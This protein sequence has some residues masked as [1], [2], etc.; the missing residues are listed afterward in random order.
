MTRKLT[1]ALSQQKQQTEQHNQKLYGMLGITIGGQRRVEVPNRNS[2]VYV[3]LRNSQSELIQAFNNRVAPSYNLPVVLKREGNRYVILDVDTTRYD[4]N[5]SSYSPYLPR[6]GNTHSFDPETGGGGDTV[7]VYPRQ[8][9]PLLAFPS[10]S[11]GSPHAI[12]S[13]YTLKKENGTWMYVGNTGTASFTPYNPPNSGTAVMGLIALDTN[14]GNPYLLINSGTTFLDTITGSSQ[15]YPY[16][17]TLTNPSDIPIAAVRLVSGTSRLTWDN[18]YDVRQFVHN[19][20]SGSAAGISSIA[21]QDEGVSQGNATTFNFVGDGVTATISGSVARIF[22][23]TNTGSSASDFEGDPNSAVLTDPSGTLFTPTW[24]KWGTASRPYLEFGADVPDKETNAGKMGYGMGGDDYEFN[25]NG[26]GTGSNRKV[27]ISDDLDVDDTIQARFFN[28]TDPAATYNITGSPHNHNSEIYA[29]LQKLPRGTMINGKI[30][31]TVSSGTL[32]L[33]LKTLDGSDPSSSNA[34]YVRIGD[35]GRSITSP[36]SCSMPTGTSL[37]NLGAAETAAKETDLFAYLIWDSNSSVVAISP[38]RIPY[39]NLVSD[40]SSTTTNEK[41]LFNHA[42]FTGTDE[43][44]VVG[45]FAATLSAS[46]FV[47]SV[48]SYTAINLIQKP[49]Y[50]TRIL[51]FASTRTPQAGS[52][53]SVSVTHEKYQV[54]GRRF[55]VD[56]YFSWTQNTTAADYI[57]LTQ[58]FSFGLSVNFAGVMNG[59]GGVV[60]TNVTSSGNSLFVRR[61]DAASGAFSTGAGKDIRHSYAAALP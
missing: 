3:R 54:V 13:P 14:S 43:V 45:R 58:P 32:N 12:I 10:G 18:I 16:I 9:M 41:H 50:E 59:L 22:V 15:I 1:D 20:P 24:L 4:N 38:A 57:Q 53:A 17:P 34:I 8:F 25:I 23:D 49:I 44:E 7:W 27:R 56:Q 30:Q 29:A 28:I 51:D 39:G 33:A 6:H 11:V 40:F 35:S 60:A 31:P 21:V 42:N 26:A 36:T 2:Y 61:Y 37:F 48:P 52:I 5:W 46:P 47:W 55:L 19:Q